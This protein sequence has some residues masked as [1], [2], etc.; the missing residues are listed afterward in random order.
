[1]APDSGVRSLLVEIETFCRRSGMAESTFGRQAVN[2]G[3]LCARLRSGKDLRL[4][5]AARIRAFMAAERARAA[6][7]EPVPASP[8][9]ETAAD[10]PSE[11]DARPFRFY[12]NR[13]KYLAFVNTCNEKWKVAERAARELAHLRP[14][15]PA[16]RVFDAG[17]G[18]G[19][20]LSHLL[21]A[22]H[23]RFPTMPFLVVGKEISL[24]DVRLSLDKLPDRFVEHPATV[25]VVTN[26]YYG[27]APWLTLRDVGQA[28]ALNWREVVLEGD[29][30]YD[31]G[32]QLRGLESFLVDGW[33]VKSHPRSGNP[34]Y[35]RPSVLILYRRDHRFLLDGVIPRPGQVAGNYD[36]VL[37]SQPWRARMSARFK[38]RKVLG[39]LARSL[40]PSG[41]LLAV[42]S[43]GRDPG[44]ELVREIWRDEDPFKVNRHA[45]IRALK[46]E[47]GREARQYNFNAASDTKSILR[48]EMHT[49]PS[50]VGPSIGSS[51]LFA[52]WNAAIYVAQIED[53]RL[54]AAIA[55]GRYLEAT[56]RMLKKHR[57]LWFNDESFVVS[58]RHGERVS[59]QHA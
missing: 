41:R 52:A 34:V 21:R 47:L 48:Y 23:K 57:G 12:D 8:A 17:M 5:T 20:V 3:K 37:A 53:E 43:F 38:V 13:Q 2:D 30:A 26:L 56:A 35:V 11:T 32:E 54:G 40:G 44:L 15:A 7:D 14:V 6:G 29:S 10:E 18:D 39:P 58:R 27:E 25:I 16:V 24:E 33:Q 9:P 42:Q 49:L 55:D 1:M 28:A 31:Y 36:L 50:E 59:G 22:M 19:T 46:D 4:D 45:L 51:T